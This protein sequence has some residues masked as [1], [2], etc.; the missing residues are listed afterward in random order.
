MIISGELDT[1]LD[2]MRGAGSV[3]PAGGAES[4]PSTDAVEPAHDHART[5]DR[6]LGE[7]S[8]HG[9]LTA[10]DL[11]V[12]LGLTP[13][14]VRRHLD[15]LAEQGLVD[16][17]V[18]PLRGSRGRGR[19]ARAY[20][21]SEG[22][23]AH[24]R[25]AY[26]ELAVSALDFLARSAGPEAVRTFATERADRLAAVARPAIEAAG[27]DPEARVEA[28]AAALTTQGYAASTRP[29]G[30]GTS[31]AGMQLCQGH[32]PVQHVATR[33]PQ[34]CE[35]EAE[36][37]SDLLGVHVQRL[38]SLAHGEHVCTTFVPTSTPPPT[39]F[40]LSGATDTHGTTTRTTGERN[41]S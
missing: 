1:E 2:T 32:C 34:F 24:L 40:T 37:F 16:E 7:I 22:G 23:H 30:D 33:Y 27:S 11:G 35:T 15:V 21:L 19:P 3:G 26:D 28:L 38:A 17:A 13:A 4:C 12:R 25:G 20:V 8:E 18:S 31:R 41:R 9:P 10:A 14:A 29:V 6:V 36:M 5:R 39:A